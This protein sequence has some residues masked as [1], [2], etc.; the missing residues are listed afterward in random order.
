MQ[1]QKIIVIHPGSLNLRIGRASDLNPLTILHAIGRRRKQTLQN[2]PKLQHHDPLLPTIATNDNQN[3]V[4]QEFEDSRLQVSHAIQAHMPQ[5]EERSGGLKRLRIATPPQQIATYNRRTVPEELPL[6]GAIKTEHSVVKK[7]D[8]NLV[9]NIY[10][11]DLLKINFNEVADYNIHFPMKRGE[12]NLH[13]NIGGS[14]TSVLSD[15][16]SIW[17]YAIHERMEIPRKSLVQYGAVLVVPDVYNRSVLRELVTL[18]LTRL[19]FRACFLLQDHVAATFGAGLGYACVVDVGDQ[20]C[21]IS[22]VEDGISQPDT[23]VRLGYGGG[24]VTQVFYALLRKCCFPY[25]ECNLEDDYDDA[26]LL[27]NLKEK[28]CHLNLEICGAQEKHF[29]V[30]KP[31]KRLRY[32]FQLGDECVVAPL[33][34]FHTELLNITGKQRLVRL[35][36]RNS[37]QSDAEDCFDAEYIRETGRVRNGR[38][39]QL[40]E[41]SMPVTGETADDELVVVDN[42]DVEERSN[43]LRNSEKDEELYYSSINGQI[44]PLDLAIVRSIERCTTDDMKRK[45]YGC[46]LLVGGGSKIPGFSKWLEQKITLQLSATTTHNRLMDQLP[47]EVNVCVKEMD[48]AMIAW[49]GAAIMS[50]LES[51]P[52]LWLIASEWEKYGLR[53]LREKATFMW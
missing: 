49:K 27:M 13:S 36:F 42:Y 20:K 32:T 33:S 8:T 24:D 38:G 16:E 50:C 2:N 40:L 26:V 44:V 12:L 23:R 51:A 29:E 28:F 52:E 53:I 1:A 34:L 14:L 37:Q 17:S 21:S 22:C 10:D 25:K 9:D 35:Q 5:H 15:L 19:K 18:L 46:I 41:G 4:M 3:E 39:D 7:E 11:Q 48:A 30:N 47:F 45:M 6:D 31:K 43:N